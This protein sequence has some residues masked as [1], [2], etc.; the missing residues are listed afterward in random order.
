MP[1]GIP[2]QEP[3]SYRKIECR[4]NDRELEL[5]PATPESDLAAGSMSGGHRHRVSPV[6]LLPP[7]TTGGFRAVRQWSGLAAA[8]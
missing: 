4:V 1:R 5:K 7:A 3:P 8:S 2:A 6:D